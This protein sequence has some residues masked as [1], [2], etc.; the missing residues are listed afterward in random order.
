MFHPSGV[1]EAEPGHAS[2][3]GY[4][5]SGD[6]FPVCRVCTKALL[7]AFCCGMNIPAELYCLMPHLKL[8]EVQSGHMR[9]TVISLL[10]RLEA[11]R[12]S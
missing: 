6:E 8:G 5:A 12:S 3:P 1:A 2:A 10:W 9:L 11:E 4:Q 7:Q